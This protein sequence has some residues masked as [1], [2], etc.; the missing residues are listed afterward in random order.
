MAKYASKRIGIL[1]G[2]F[3]PVHSGH[4]HMAGC[5]LKKLRLDR[6]IFV[7]AYIPPHKR[8]HPGATAKDRLRMLRLAVSGKRKFEVSRYELRKKGTSYS[9]RTVA[10]LAKKYG[11]NTKLFFLIGADSVPGLSKW[12]DIGRLRKIVSFAVAP[13]AGYK[14]SRSRPG[15]IKLKM[16][17]KDVSSTAIRRLVKKKKGISSLVPAEIRRYIQGKNLYG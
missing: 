16:P 1:G 11:K 6:V 17:E 13:R 3:N 5:A 14:I 9:V 7:P 15:I 4:L 12:K 8:I 10:H 2:T